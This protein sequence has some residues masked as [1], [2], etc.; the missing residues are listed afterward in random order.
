MIC[1]EDYKTVASKKRFLT[2]ERK[3]IE[4][5]L[6]DIK[7][8]LKSAALSGRKPMYL[9]KWVSNRDVLN[10]QRDLKI[11]KELYNNLSK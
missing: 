8:I 5:L 7:S 3:L 1:L 2:R 9:G 6:I 4:E 10:Y 11:I